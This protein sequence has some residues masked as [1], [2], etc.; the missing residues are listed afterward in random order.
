MEKP[1]DK[2]PLGKPRCK[3]KINITIDR[4]GCGVGGMNWIDQA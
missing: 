1:E 2:R 3:W 4:S